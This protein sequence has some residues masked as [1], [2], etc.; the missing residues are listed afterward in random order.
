LDK[1]SEVFTWR[2]SDLTGVS[3]DIIEHKLEVNPSARPKKQRLCKMSDKKVAAA[4]AEVQ[5]LLDVGFIREVYYPNWLANIVMVKKKN[6][7][8]RMCTDF[9]DLNKSCPKDDFPLTRIDK[10]VDFVAGCEIMA[11]LD[12]FLGYHQVWLREEDQDKTSFITPFSTYCYLR[13][14]EGLKNAGSTFCRMTKVILKEQLERNVFAYVDDIVGVSRKTETQLQ[15]LAETFAS[16]QR[17]QVKLNL[18]KFVFGDSRGKVLGC[19]VLVKGIEAN[20]DKIK[21][22]VCMKPLKSRKEVQKLT[23]K[24]AALNQFMAKIAEQSLPFFKVLRGSSAFKWGS[25]Q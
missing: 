19:L 18:E 5:R 13:M 2:T 10:V 15:D 8:W 6:G 20:P 9:T 3:R 22:I 7:K 12:Y 25:E 21:A 24:I 1:N 17:A 16:M 14:P 4:K 23:G 11:L